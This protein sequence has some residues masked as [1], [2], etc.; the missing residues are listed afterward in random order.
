MKEIIC[1]FGA[2]PKRIRKKLNQGP[3]MV[4]FGASNYPW[5]LGT[6]PLGP[7][8]DPL[9]Y[10]RNHGQCQIYLMFLQVALLDMTHSDPGAPGEHRS[11]HNRKRVCK[12]PLA[13]SVFEFSQS[14]FSQSVIFF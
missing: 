1:R 2:S 6:G 13:Q 8:C 3:E 4:N 14:L 9:L 10:N 12:T 5:G 11:Q 7:P